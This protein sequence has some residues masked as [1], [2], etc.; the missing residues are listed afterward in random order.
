MLNVDSVGNDMTRISARGLCILAVVLLFISVQ[1]TAADTQERCHEAAR[2]K[3]TDLHWKLYTDKERGFELL[4]PDSLLIVSKRGTTVTFRHSIP[5]EHTDPCDFDDDASSLNEL[6]DFDVTVRLWREG[7]GETVRLTSTGLVISRFL[8]DDTLK[9]EKGFI[10]RVSIG[11][12]EGFCI[13]SGVEGCGM[14]DYYFP[15]NGEITLHVERKHI[16]EFRPILRNYREYLSLP[17]IINPEREAEI[18][19]RM[20]C[21]FRVLE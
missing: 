3:S 5:F 17:G 12:L 14:D 11:S 15:V 8:R 10:D 16:T 4:Y 21:T 2:A 9:V 13:T 19:E 18:F 20:F 6:V 7:L 1:K